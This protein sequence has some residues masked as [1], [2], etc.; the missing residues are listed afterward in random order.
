MLEIVF[1]ILFYLLA[2]FGL[3]KVLFFYAQKSYLKSIEPTTYNGLLSII[4]PCR[5]EERRL[6]RL[7]TSLQGQTFKN[8]EVLVVDDASLDQTKEIAARYSTKVIEVKEYD[9]TWEGKSAACYVGALQAK[10]DYLL[11]LDADV[12]LASDALA[13]IASY[14]PTEAVLTIQPYHQMQSA[15]EQLSLFFNLIVFLG[16]GFTR[17]NSKYQTKRGFYGPFMLINKELYFKVGGHSKVKNKVLEDMDLGAIFVRQGIPIY[18]LPHH[19]LISFRMYP[20][21]LATLF[22]GWS[23]NMILGASRAGIG[24]FLTVLGIISTSFSLPLSLAKMIWLG[25][26]S[27]ILIYALLYL[28]YAFLL[29]LSCRPLGSFS[30]GACFLFPLEALFFV[31]VFLA[32][33]FFSIFRIPINWRGRRIKL[34]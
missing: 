2:G 27:G 5:N 29:Y 14:L 23:K 11:F 9:P 24:I 30:L 26:P 16:L 20:E 19:S 22:A 12:Y 6:A 15:Y 1:Q 3:L 32:S 28:G 17:H 10:G 7:L 31:L 33:S 21:G 13:L 8:F 25:L 4:I 18:I 34:R